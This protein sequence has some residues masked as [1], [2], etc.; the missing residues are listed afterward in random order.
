[1]NNISVSCRFFSRE[2]FLRSYRA[3]YVTAL[4]T[5]MFSLMVFGADAKGKATV[6]GSVFEPLPLT[7]KIILNRLEKGETFMDMGFIEY[8]T[9]L[10][11]SIPVSSS[12]PVHVR[13]LTNSSHQEHTQTDENGKFTFNNFFGICEV[14]ARKM[15]EVD[16]VTKEA[17]ARC[18]VNGSQNSSAQ[19]LLRTDLVS[20]KGRVILSDGQPVVGVKIIGIPCVSDGA[21]SE[22]THLYPEQYSVTA[23]DGTYEL[24]DLRPAE[25]TTI[26]QYLLNGSATGCNDLIAEKIMVKGMPDMAQVSV[27]V[28]LI[29]EESLANARRYIAILNKEIV[30]RK[31]RLPLAEKPGVFLPQITGHV[32][33]APDIVLKK[34]NGGME[35]NP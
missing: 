14:S 15:V 32:I 19:L 2:V 29:S 30:K 25:F 16:G 6:R 35:V 33:I 5:G 11:T 34:R 31:N 23:S 22:L 21:S 27:S 13:S 3:V 7:P 8:E 28:P 24:L 12:I 17:K 20:I 9:Y 10:R 26:T 1:M 18:I 4:F